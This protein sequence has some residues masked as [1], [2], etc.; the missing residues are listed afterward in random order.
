M[1]GR[2]KTMI[3]ATQTAPSTATGATSL[4]LTPS[5][6]PNSSE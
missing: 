3:A 1:S 4:V 2:Y 5:T 6:S